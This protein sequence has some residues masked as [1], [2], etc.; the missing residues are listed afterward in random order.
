MVVA[1]DLLYESEIHL[2]FE[3]VRVNR[4]SHPQW[5]EIRI[6]AFKTTHSGIGAQFT[7]EPPEG[8]I[9]WGLDLLIW[10]N[11]WFGQAPCSFVKQ[12]CPNQ[13]PLCYSPK[14]S[15]A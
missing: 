5:L 14:M 15:P 8:A 7:W 3:N 1:S 13:S 4:R 9:L 2:N 12:P 6:K 11:A 10:F